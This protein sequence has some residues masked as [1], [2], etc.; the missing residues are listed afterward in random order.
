MNV[1]ISET[2]YSVGEKDDVAVV[3]TSILFGTAVGEKLSIS[4]QT[5]NGDAQ[6]IK[7]YT[8]FL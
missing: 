8:M 7:Q 4:Y 3:C 6:G 2:V 5:A 1:G